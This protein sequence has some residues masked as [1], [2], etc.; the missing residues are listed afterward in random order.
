MTSRARVPR[1]GNPVQRELGAAGV[2]QQPLVR[3]VVGGDRAEPQHVLVEGPQTTDV[4]RE[5]D[6]PTQAHGCRRYA[7]PRVD[8][9][10]E[11][12]DGVG[13]V[14]GRVRERV[15]QLARP[16]RPARARAAPPS[17][18]PSTVTPRRRAARRTPP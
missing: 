10:P 8:V 13:G 11:P 4:L 12:P 14:D 9:D 3:V 17:T 7:A 2:E 1:I 6:H 5:Q 15:A 18:G 16:T